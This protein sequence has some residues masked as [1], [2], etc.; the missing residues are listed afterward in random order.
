MNDDQQGELSEGRSP[1][2]SPCRHSSGRRRVPCAGR[3]RR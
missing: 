2:F 1:E 3:A